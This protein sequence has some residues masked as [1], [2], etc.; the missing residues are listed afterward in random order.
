MK[1]P[2]QVR[3]T[4]VYVFTAALLTAIGAILFQRSVH[5]GLTHHVDAQLKSR[6]IRVSHT[7]KRAGP[8]AVHTMTPRGANVLIEVIDP[9]GQF[10][11]GSPDLGGMTLLDT[12]QQS[13]AAHSPGGYQNVGIGP[14]YRVYVQPV[15]T[16]DGTWL[17]VAA[18]PLDTQNALTDTVTGYLVIAVVVVVVLGGIGA[19]LLAGAALLPVEQLRRE[20]AQLSENDP[21]S[22][23]YVPGTGDEIAALAESVNGLLAR[24]SAGLARQ[25]RFV[26]DASHEVRAPL[27]N[28]RTTLELA[29]RRVRTAEEL[30]EAV[31]Y[32]EGEVIR[33]GQLV[34]DLLVLA[35]SDEKVPVS[36]LPDQRALP[37]LEAAAL[38]ARPTADAKCVDVV[39]D[40][41]PDASAALHPGMI[42]QVLD[43]LLSNAVRHAPPDSRIV[44]TAAARPDSLLISVEDQGPG[45]PDGFTEQAFE[46]F[47]RAEDEKADPA[48]EGAG[49][50]A[51]GTGLGLAVVR[52]IARAHGGDAEAGNGDSGGAVVRVRLPRGD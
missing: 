7:V 22:P 28:L 14:D 41:D 48:D 50:G 39:V 11:V 34:D 16:A 30:T 35:A 36:L 6:A 9:K 46:R 18:T 32:C 49:S 19:W 38:A 8:N 13:A 3:L 23:L 47:R 12:A 2:I 42:R 24:F 51:G 21:S 25:R 43:N 37:L 4:A 15:T 52:A 33:L 17:A 1:L 20:V 31:R 44:L 45:F 29:T 26:A 27:A 5:I 10:A 40:A